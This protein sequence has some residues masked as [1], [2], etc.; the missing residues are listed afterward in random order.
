MGVVRGTAN[1]FAARAALI[2]QNTPGVPGTAENGDRFGS[3]IAVVGGH[4]AVSTPA[5]NSGTGAV[6]VFPGTATGSVSFGPRTLAAPG[7]GARIGAAFH[8]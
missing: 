5:E 8:R 2:G 7:S 4:V 3:R 1:G 6:R